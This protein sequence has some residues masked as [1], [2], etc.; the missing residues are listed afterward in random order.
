MKRIYFWG[1]LLL[2]LAAVGCYD[3]KGSY[4]YAE[5][6]AI[7]IEDIEPSY[8]CLRNADLLEITPKITSSTEGEIAADNPNYEYSCRI[9]KPRGQGQF[10]DSQMW[11][12][13]NPDS[14]QAFTW[15]P[16]EDT[17]EYICVYTVRDKRTDVATNYQFGLQIT[18]STYEGW[19]VLSSDGADE[20]ARLDMV[21]VIDENRIQVL[22]DLLANNELVSSLHHPTQIMFD[23]SVYSSRLFTIYLL[24]EEG[25]YK[26]NTDELTTDVRYPQWADYLEKHFARCGQP[27]HTVLDLACGTGTMTCLLAERGYE[28]IGVDRSAD[29]LS[30]AAEKGRQVSGIP[31]LFLQQSMQE[32]DLYGTVDA[33][34]CCLD[35]VNY[36]TRPAELLRAFRRVCLFLVPGGL[37]LFDINTPEK[38]QGLDGGIFLDETEDTYCVWR[39][40]YS[41]RSR[42][43]TYGMDLFFRE[44]DGLWR[45]EEEVHQERAYTPEELTALLQEA[46]FTAVR[47]HGELKL[48]PPKPGEQR[49]FFTA[50]KER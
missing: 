15:L 6:P 23:R 12:V 3:D 1:C 42:L 10:D 4:D 11:H 8:T 43:C 46:G 7:S 50:R 16:N 13:I 45:R 2:M 5:I 33:C 17:G 47:Q 40:D 35:S 29:M 49:I 39:A 25:G 26:L 14:T 27:I 21:S 37:F 19:L 44:E 22:P 9:G 20:R 38:L 28:T 31:P 24:T 48:R 41:R 18:S 30:V 32:L 34:V 36:V